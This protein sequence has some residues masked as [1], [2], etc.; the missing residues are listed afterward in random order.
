MKPS[1]LASEHL[2]LKLHIFIFLSPH[3]LKTS[4]FTSLRFSK[5]LSENSKTL[6]LQGL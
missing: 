3:F 1:L 2:P 5:R 6:V 4:V